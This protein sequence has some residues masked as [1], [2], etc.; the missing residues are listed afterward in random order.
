MDI[1]ALYRMLQDWAGDNS[2]GVQV[3][4]LVFLVLLLN[5]ILR[6]TRNLGQKVIA[7]SWERDQPVDVTSTDATRILVRASTPTTTLH[8]VPAAPIAEPEQ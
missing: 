1:T 3:L 4:V 2:V 6:L 8:L 5:L 7:H